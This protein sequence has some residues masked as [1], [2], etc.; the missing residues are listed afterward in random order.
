MIA[1]LKRLGHSLA[2]RMGYDIIRYI[3]GQIPNVRSEFQGLS[4]A[5]AA[6]QKLLDDYSFETVLDIGCG[7]GEQSDLFLKHGK[8]VTAVDYG[9]S[10]YFNRNKH[11]INCLI[12]DF[13]AMQFEEQ[14]DCVWASH[15]LEHQLNTGI[16]LQNIFKAAKEGAAV[17]ITVP[18]LQHEI[19]GGHVSLWNAGLLLYNL[20]LAGFDCREVSILRYG[21][22]I[23]VIVKKRSVTLPEL[24][25]DNGDVERI[26]LF[27]PEGLHEGFYGDIVSHNWNHSH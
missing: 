9:K 7:A 23:S 16:F 19:L 17:C 24:T 11:R 6:M 18:P 26:L 20:V 8:K 21:Y 3:P 10:I 5:G 13:N 27:L 1:K 12:G 25:F 15:V 14:F 22:N 2:R 4:S